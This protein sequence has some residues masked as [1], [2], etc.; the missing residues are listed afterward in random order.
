MS[1][2]FG[3]WNFDKKPIDVEKLAAANKLLTPYAPD[4][5]E[6][7][8]GDG[9]VL[10]HYAFKTTP[11]SR[12]EKQPFVSE[13]RTV[14]AW[15]G[16][17]DNREELIQ[18]LGTP[19]EN[20]SAD[21]DI[22]SAAYDRWGTGCFAKLLG[23]WAAA[24][25][26]EDNQRL[27]LAKDFMGMRPLY[28]SFDR[29]GTKWS[30]VLDPLVLFESKRWQ[31]DERY[32]AGWLALYPPADATPYVGIQAVPPSCFVSVTSETTSVIRYWD[33][34]PGKR[35]AYKTDS[36]YEEHFRCAFREAVRRRLR[37][38]GAI[39]AELSGGM[40]SP[41]VTCMAD[42]IAASLDTPVDIYTLSYYNDAEPHGD[43]RPYFS[44]VE[45]KRGRQGCHID[46]AGEQEIDIDW[47]TGPWLTPMRVS[48]KRNEAHIQRLAFFKSHGI[49]IVLSGMGGDEMTGGVPTGTPE[50]QDLIAQGQLR[51]L[52]HMLKLWALAKRKPWFHLLAEALHGFLPLSIVSRSK[53]N[54]PALWLAAEFTART[55]HVRRGFT[56]R[57]RVR[58]PLPSYQN[59]LAS[60]ETLR[61]QMATN[62][63][64]NDFPTE[65]RYPF[66]DRNFL[67]F[68][69]AIPRDQVIRPG[70]RRSLMRRA[71]RG[72]V[73]E[74]VLER[75]RKAYSGRSR[76]LAISAEAHRECGLVIAMHAARLGIV[77]ES[78]LRG[79]LDSVA[80]NEAISLVSVSRT[81]ALEAWL[82]N[83]HRHDMF[84]GDDTITEVKKLGALPCT[85]SSRAP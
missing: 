39:C 28:Y 59:N 7:H 75:R 41:S 13:S 57:I 19:L 11:E 84:V 17:L 21:V 4:A 66:L 64:D 1:A 8:V 6:Q 62:E 18:R 56:S 71:L 65:T 47:T 68:M 36:A 31:L 24:I 9:I 85:S 38:D 37:S 63:L 14:V 58:G 25:W 76:R 22:V 40:D 26:D 35:I 43:E 10:V 54:R 29:N 49:R 20:H 70:Y 81:L 69:F 80:D 51:Q 2:L 79:V 16:R 48:N 61:R 77:S 82:R 3:V 55:E 52:A 46:L 72:L 50:L 12:H 34:D 32:V 23:D 5:F 33:F 67:E 45:Q 60:L 44:A 78:A 53:Q 74:E 83:V 73:P 27:L 30:S 42:S 15:D